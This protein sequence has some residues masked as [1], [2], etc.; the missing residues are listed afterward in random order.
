MY[1]GTVVPD[2]NEAIDCY[3]KYDKV[4]V[5]IGSKHTIGRSEKWEARVL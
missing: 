4:I 1:Q 5:A 3:E 2:R